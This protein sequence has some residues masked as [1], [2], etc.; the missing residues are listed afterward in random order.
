[1]TIGFLWRR[2]DVIDYHSGLLPVAA[3][4]CDRVHAGTSLLHNFV[5]EDEKEEYRRELEK[6]QR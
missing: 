5:V 2:H 3:P 4:V 6:R 1:M